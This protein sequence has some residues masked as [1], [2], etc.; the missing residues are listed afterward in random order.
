MMT[1]D[2]IVVGAGPAGSAAAYDLAVHNFS[3]LLLDKTRFPRMKACAGGLTIKAVRALRYP[4]EPVTHKVCYNLEVS[5]RTEK[6][7][8]LKSLKPVALMT[9]R[10]EFDFFCLNETLK[11]GT[12]FRVVKKLH[13]VREQEKFVELITE[14]GAL[15]SKFLIGADGANSS[16]RK[17]FSPF[18]EFKRGF[19]IEAK[20]PLVARRHYEMTFDFGVVK[21]GYGW[22]FPKQDHLNIGLYT[23]DDSVKLKAN[24][25]YHYCKEKTGSNILK[26]MAAFSIGFGGWGYSPRLKRIFLVG[27][28]AGLADPLLGEGLHNA[29]KSGQAAAHAIIQEISGG[30]PALKCYHNR[31]LPIKTDT[32]AAYKIARRFY[33]FPALGCALLSFPLMGNTL[34]KG[35]AMG[36]TLSEIKSRFLKL[37]LSEGVECVST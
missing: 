12:E 32:L 6:H 24:A 8:T 21:S 16:I 18:P 2:V 11:A 37:S 3:V 31:I 36:L 5:R 7:T 14:Q 28:A 19:A 27:D 33:R 25:L 10:S 9:E 1:Y 17:R 22:V 29:I 30:N 20:A 34:M 13:D 15:R 23:L 4:I 26:E 35:C